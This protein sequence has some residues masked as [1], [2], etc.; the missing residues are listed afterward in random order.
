M[1]IIKNQT[2]II[3]IRFSLERLNID[4]TSSDKLRDFFHIIDKYMYIFLHKVK[5]KII[6]N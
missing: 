2:Q 6:C 3:F 4:V 5:Y 1:H